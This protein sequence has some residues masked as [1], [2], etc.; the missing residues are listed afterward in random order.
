MNTME[1]QRDY[2]KRRA[3]EEDEAAIRAASDKARALHEELAS[4]YRDSATS[5]PDVHQGEPT[6]TT[7]RPKEFRILE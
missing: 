1:S 2:L 3:L 5:E 7:I 6:V 4:R